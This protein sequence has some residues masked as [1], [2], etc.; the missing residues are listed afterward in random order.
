MS[1]KEFFGGRNVFITGGTGFMGKVLIEK[2][3]RSCPDIGN[4][5]MLVRHKKEKDSAAR[6]KDILEFK[7]C[8]NFYLLFIQ[9]D[10]C[11]S[12]THSSVFII[13]QKKKNYF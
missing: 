7:V 6:I 9:I 10:I 8:F 5:F 4:I 12:L 11:R 3:V 2:L 1:I 13:I